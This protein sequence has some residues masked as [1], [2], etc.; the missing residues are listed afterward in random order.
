MKNTRLYLFSILSFAVAFISCKDD[1]YDNKSPFDN[2]VYLDVAENSDTQITTFKKTLTE[3]KKEFSVVLS[4]PASQDVRVNVEVEPSLIDVYNARHNTSW[5]LLDSRYYTLSADKITI[6]AGKTISDQLNLE[7]KDLDGS[8]GGEELPI[9]ETYL[10]PITISH[11]EGG[12][13]TLRS[14]ATAYYLVKRSSAITSAASL[15]DNWINFPTLDKASEGSMLFNN[16]TAVTYEA[17][18][19]VDDF[20]KHSE[21]STIMGV[22]NYLLLR[23]GDASFP[24]QQLQFDGSG[25]SAQTPGFGKFPKKD[26]AKLLNAG[27]WYHI[28]ATYSYATREVCLYVN[29]KLQSKGSDLG[30]AASTPF[31]LAGRAFYDLYLQDPETYKD[32][33][34][35]GNFRQFFLGKSYDDSRQLNGDITEVRVWNVARNEQ[36]IWD[37]MYDV[38]PQTPGLIGYWKFDEG[39]GNVIK[40]WTGNGNDAVAEKDLEWPEGIEVPQLNKE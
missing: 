6:P 31:N 39:A 1:E 36:E 26:E 8:T 17:I 27:E 5:R 18:I 19:R 2:V 35:W 12:V 11:V 15:R 37:N 25:D 9:D 10:V 3:L 34:D 21:I 40:D 7:L 4:Y 29:G 28:A 16:L 23:I 38:D 24:R 32:Y 30:N 20:S 22:E 33:K 13:S 14:S